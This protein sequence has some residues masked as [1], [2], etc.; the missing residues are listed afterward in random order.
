M[1]VTTRYGVINPTLSTNYCNNSTCNIYI[2]NN[3]AQNT[4]QF[5]YF[6]ILLVQVSTFPVPFA[7]NVLCD[8]TFSTN[9]F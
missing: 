3:C 4:G 5:N 9:T 6:D 1:T 8:N 7:Y 2:S